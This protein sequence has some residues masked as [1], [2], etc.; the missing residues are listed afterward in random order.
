M[1][2]TLA[3]FLLWI[4]CITYAFG[5]AP[6]DNPNTLQLITQLATNNTADVNPLVVALFNVMG[7][8]PIMYGCF[9]CF[10]GRGQKFPA[11]PFLLAAFGVGAFAILPYLALRQANPTF[12]APKNW[13]L[14]G[15]DANWVGIIIAIAI[16][17]LGF[18][19]IS[20]GDWGEFVEQWQ[21]DR[22]IHVMSLDFCLL[23]TLFP[24]LLKDDMARRGL[25]DQRIFWAVTGLP[26]LGTVAYLAL[27]PPTLEAHQNQPPAPPAMVEG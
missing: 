13:L 7:I 2:R 23:S 16:G 22:F 6:P 15:L 11:W 18:Y 25:T 20:Q 14:K 27:R 17:I 12:N 19:G 24:F 8:L 5:F 4:G 21:T 10:D 26:L 1:I 9:L 3:L